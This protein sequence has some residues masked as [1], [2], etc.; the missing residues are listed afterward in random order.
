MRP[1]IT[2]TCVVAAVVFIVGFFVINVPS[3]EALCLGVKVSPFPTLKTR[4]SPGIPAPPAPS[5]ARSIRPP[6]EGVTTF[7]PRENRRSEEEAGEVD[8]GFG[9]LIVAV[10][11]TAA[12]ESFVVASVGFETNGVGIPF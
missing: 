10:V 6:E 7:R 5:E 12:E 1:S 9:E 11:V 2:S 4:F 3:T 8:V